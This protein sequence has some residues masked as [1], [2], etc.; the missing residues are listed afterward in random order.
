MVTFFVSFY[1]DSW[2]KAI[3][4]AMHHTFANKL[5]IYHHLSNYAKSYYLRLNFYARADK[6]MVN[7]WMGAKRLKVIC[8]H[9]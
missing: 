4:R 7:N 5:V 6:F 8:L 9:K 1:V 3:L 2:G